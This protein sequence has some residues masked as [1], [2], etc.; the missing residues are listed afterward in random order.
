M[1]VTIDRKSAI[2]IRQQLKGAIEHEICFGALPPGAPLPSVR[3]LAERVGVAPMTVS[4]VYGEL[5]AEGRITGRTGSGTFVADCSLA[6]ANRNE[7]TGRLRGDIDAVIDVLAGG[8]L[9]GGDVM[10]P[11]DVVPVGLPGGEY[12][13]GDQPGAP[14]RQT[15]PAGDQPC[16]EKQLS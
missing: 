16:R 14:V 5:K 10:V 11:V 8:G 4:K 9:F 6:R 3:E 1:R 7:C 2:S 15:Q 12:R 13:E